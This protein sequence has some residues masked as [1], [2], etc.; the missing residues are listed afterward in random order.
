MSETGLLGKLRPACT[1]PVGEFLIESGWKGES[2]RNFDVNSEPCLEGL[3]TLTRPSN[4]LT[5]LKKRLPWV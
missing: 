2:E 4:D 1:S 5:I 3:S